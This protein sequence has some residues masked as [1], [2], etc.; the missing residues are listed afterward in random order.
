MSAVFIQVAFLAKHL[1]IVRS[2]LVKPLEVP[3]LV[4]LT[5]MANVVCLCRW[6]LA[7]GC[8]HVHKYFSV[9]LGLLGTYQFCTRTHKSVPDTCRFLYK[10]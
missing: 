7:A 4:G 2:I 9:V 6:S 8:A 1:E 5:L 3:V 10:F